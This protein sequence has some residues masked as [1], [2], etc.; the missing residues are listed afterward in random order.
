M[1]CLSLA[2]IKN[3]FIAIIVCA[4]KKEG[5]SEKRNARR[6]IQQGAAVLVLF[7]LNYNRQVAAA[8]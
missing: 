8:V 2:P 7:C 5:R 6:T 3:R 4:V 1:I